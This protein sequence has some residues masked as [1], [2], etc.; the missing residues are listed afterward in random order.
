[1][2][3]VASSL[4][5]ATCS[6]KTFQ[7]IEFL[8]VILMYVLFDLSPHRKHLVSQNVLLD[9]CIPSPQEQVYGSQDNTL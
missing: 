9:I 2:K 7:K 1:M 4:L 8:I 6:F 5:E 3:Q